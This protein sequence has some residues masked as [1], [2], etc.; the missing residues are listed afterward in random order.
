MGKQIFGSGRRAFLLGVGGLGAAN[1]LHQFNNASASAREVN[2]YL[3]KGNKAKSTQ[4][5]RQMAASKGGNFIRWIP[6]K[7]SH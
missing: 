1:L 7:I 2:E 3:N 5:L 6:S 4:S